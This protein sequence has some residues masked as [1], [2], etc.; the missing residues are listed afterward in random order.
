MSLSNDIYDRMG[1]DIVRSRV[2]RRGRA[3]WIAGVSVIMMLGVGF[4]KLRFQEIKWPIV[5]IVVAG[6]LI[7]LY[8]SYI[9]R[10]RFMDEVMMYDH[11][12]MQYH[13]TMEGAKDA[14]ILRQLCKLLLGSIVVFAIYI[15]YA[16]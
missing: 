8:T 9:D 11:E 15:M 7:Y 5:A 6:V 2:A 13:H 1:F 10:V 3:F 16:A 4:A 12:Q 14:S